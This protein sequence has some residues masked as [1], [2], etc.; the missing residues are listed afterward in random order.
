MVGYFALWLGLA[1]YNGFLYAVLRRRDYL[2]YLAYVLC[3]GATVA[4]GNDLTTLVVP[5][6]TGR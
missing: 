3:L 4:V 1:A 6:R 5:G 2:L